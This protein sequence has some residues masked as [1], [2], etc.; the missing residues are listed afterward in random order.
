[1]P[2]A[3]L[4]TDELDRKIGA[5]LGDLEIIFEILGPRTTQAFVS[6][7]RK[8]GIGLVDPDRH[9]AWIDETVH[10]GAL[11]RLARALAEIERVKAWTIPTMPSAEV[12]AALSE[13]AKA[14]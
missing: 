10:T 2:D 3:A 6:L 5:F 13:K 8:H 7:A 12:W 4:I 1:M 9:R 11:W 14:A